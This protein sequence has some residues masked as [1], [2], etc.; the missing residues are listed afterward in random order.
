MGMESRLMGQ[1]ETEW[2][3]VTG[4]LDTENYSHFEFIFIKMFIASTTNLLTLL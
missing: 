3:T 4:S 2:E 1:R